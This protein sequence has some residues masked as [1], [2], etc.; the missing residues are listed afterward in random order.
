M[1]KRVKQHVH[2]ASWPDRIAYGKFSAIRCKLEELVIQS[3]LVHSS[4]GAYVR[5]F[6]AVQAVCLY[7]RSSVRMSQSIWCYQG[8]LRGFPPPKKL[9]LNRVRYK[10]Y[11]RA[12]YLAAAICAT[13][14]PK[15]F[16]T[17]RPPSKTFNGETATT[18]T[19]RTS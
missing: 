5:E 8:S 1:P 11:F 17:L 10:S 18:S 3:S 7:N 13:L 4:V 14:Y 6:R 19:L 16:L 15:T 9:S 2:W 12:L